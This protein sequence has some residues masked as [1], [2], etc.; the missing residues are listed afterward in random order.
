MCHVVCGVYPH[1]SSWRGE[2]SSPV[3]MTPVHARLTDNIERERGICHGRLSANAHSTGLYK[4]RPTG[5]STGVTR[6][7]LLLTCMLCTVHRTQDKRDCSKVMADWRSIYS[8]RFTWYYRCLEA[9]V[10]RMRYNNYWRWSHS[11]QSLVYVTVGCPSVCPFV[12]PII[13]PQ[14]RRA[15]GLLLSA[16]RTEG[17]DRQRRAPYT[18]QQRRRSTELTRLNTSTGIG[19]TYLTFDLIAACV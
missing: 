9:L 6:Q 2:A 14:H 1:A 5:L 8:S 16:T 11:M 3:R 15:A 13:R 18:Q 7:R 17:I 19:Q 12:C 4:I 10:L